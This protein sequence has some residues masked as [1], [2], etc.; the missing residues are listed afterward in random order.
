MLNGELKTNIKKKQLH[1]YC[2]TSLLTLYQT[3]PGFYDPEIE[4]F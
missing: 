2:V 4:D 1:K 3:I